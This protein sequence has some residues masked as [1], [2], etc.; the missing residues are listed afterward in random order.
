MR[1]FY[2]FFI[3]LFVSGFVSLASA[4]SYPP[5]GQDCGTYT[6]LEI[7]RTSKAG[8][9]QTGLTDNNNANNDRR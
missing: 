7:I 6:V 5:T 1:K 2:M 8:I 4:Q 3:A 9:F